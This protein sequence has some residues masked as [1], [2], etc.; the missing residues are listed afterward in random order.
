M[1]LAAHEAVSAVDVIATATG[2]SPLGSGLPG[3]AA[4]QFNAT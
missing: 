4:T 3:R 2:D 1:E